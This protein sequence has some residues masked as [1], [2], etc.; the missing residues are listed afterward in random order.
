MREGRPAFRSLFGRG[1]EVRADAPGRVNLIGEHT[2]TSG[3][4]VLPAAIPQ[5]AIVDLAARADLLVNA[6]SADVPGSGTPATYRVGAETR[7]GD[8]LDYVQAVT[9]VLARQGYALGG[10]DLLVV[11]DVPLG[12]G[13]ASSA[14]LEVAL[15][16]ALREAFSL[17]L[18]DVALA[19]VAQ[20]AEN[21]FVGA[22]VG[23]MDQMA[24]SL[25]LGDA[26]LFI[27]T[28]SL[29]YERVELPADLEL[30]VLDSGVPH[31]HATGAY[32]ARRS[33][34]RLAAELL[35]LP[36]LRDA[37]SADLTRIAELPAPLDRRARHVVT[38]NDR[39]LRAVRALKDG[40]LP[41][42]GRLLDASHASLRDDFEVS[43]SEVDALAALA[44]EDEDV[45]GAR[46]TGGGFG[47][48]V[49][50]LA[51]RGAGR[52][53]GARAVRL[54]G[55]RTGCAGAVLVPARPV[56]GAQEAAT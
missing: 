27:D 55:E 21:D 30:V 7:R 54:Y 33:E 32:R 40:D 16:R 37:S 23:V 48:A 15:L 38:E 8:W 19:L 13:L 49:V 10:F 43:T 20:R 36:A 6:F 25:A 44:R 46:I 41:E 45:F 5:R 39:V 50:A 56:S 47:G 11:S 3:G 28:R 35:G 29:A 17:P 42:L 4:F 9:F 24:A 52:A 12:A 2:D 51:R 53:A 14:A 34:V 31:A 22:P 26:A 18:D 1:P